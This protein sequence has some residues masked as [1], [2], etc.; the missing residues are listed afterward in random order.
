MIVPPEILLRRSA[1]A[2]VG[3]LAILVAS[4][5]AAD[6][7]PRVS[8]FDGNLAEAIA[9]KHQAQI[10]V[11]SLASER[12][13]SEVVRDFAEKM[14]KHHEDSLERLE[15]ISSIETDVR[16]FDIDSALPMAA[17]GRNSSNGHAAIDLRDSTDP[18]STTDLKGG[19]VRKVYD[20]GESR[21]VVVGEPVPPAD[22]LDDEPS[23]DDDNFDV[24]VTLEEKLEN[25]T[26]GI[27]TAGSPGLSKLPAGA[28]N[29]KSQKEINRR[30]R[31]RKTGMTR[32][33]T[34]DEYAEEL[35][36][37]LDAETAGMKER[38]D[39]VFPANDA[40]DDALAD[41]GRRSDRAAGAAPA[42]E[43]GKASETKSNQRAAGARLHARQ[44]DHIWTEAAARS[45]KLSTDRMESVG[46][47]DF[48]WTYIHDQFSRHVEMKCALEAMNDA[49]GNDLRDAFERD[50]DR[51]NDHIAELKAVMQALEAVSRKS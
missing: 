42:A 51:I 18:V 1:I 40:G 44:M 30:L 13:T 36:E 10:A 28:S 20:R 7:K 19:K 37:V 11:S 49:V 17:H 29:A 16:Q 5:H 45:L 27:E 9:Y 23:V 14:V 43:N 38:K 34:F 50:L 41:N 47:Y 12:A 31:Q 26:L 32:R 15:R 35:A 33:P 8:T 3:S 2:C 6:R 46:G 39:R 48:D 21:A 4:A 24:V 22:E 25:N